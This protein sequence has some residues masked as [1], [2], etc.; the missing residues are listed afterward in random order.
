M[1]KILV[2]GATGNIGS[3]VVA[4]LQEQNASVRAFVRDEHKAKAM[5]GRSVELVTG[6]FGDKNTVQRALENVHSVF[7]ACSN[8][9]RQVE[10][11]TNVIDA[12]LAAG[13]QRIVKLSALGAGVGSSVPFWDWHGRIE[14]HLKASG[15]PFV[16]L[17]PSFIMTNL[18][19]A[20]EGIQ[21]QG[22]LFAPAEDARISMIHPQDVATSAAVALTS[23]DHNGKTYM[24]TGLEV[25]TY[26][27]V[28]KEL[29]SAT[30]QHIPFVAVPDEAATQA[31]VASGLPIFVAGQIVTV[32]KALRGGAYNQTSN[33][34]QMLTGYAPRSFAQFALEHAHVFQQKLQPTH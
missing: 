33:S 31:M 14:R 5:L 9:P 12:A 30:G 25:I 17:Q 28:A 26:E 2:T 6:E 15:I 3:K 27:Q 13:V 23:E 7:L 32:F 29:S 1:K 11:E 4:E 34:V 22:M 16:I 21:Q 24:L 19:A 8:D 18:L 10:Y 20:A